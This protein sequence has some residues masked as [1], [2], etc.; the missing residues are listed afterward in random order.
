MI[1]YHATSP[2]KAKMYREAGRIARPVRGFTTLQ[3]AML[4]SM[5]VHRSVIYQIEGEPAYKLPDH[6]NEFG[7]AWWIDEDVTVFKCVVSV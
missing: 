1:L 3:A 7:Q 4:W 5:K 6:H 2:K